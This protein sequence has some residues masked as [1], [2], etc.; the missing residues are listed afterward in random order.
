MLEK[1]EQEINWEKQTLQKRSTTQKKQTTRNTVK[2][3]YPG[4]VASYEA[5]PENE[6]GL[7]YKAPEPTSFSGWAS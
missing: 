4:L 2:E 6:V 1:T 7:V 3:N 5:Q